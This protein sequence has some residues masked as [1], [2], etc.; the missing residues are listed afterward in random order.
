MDQ[1]NEDLASTLSGFQ[2]SANNT[3]QGLAAYIKFLFNKNFKQNSEFTKENLE[4]AINRTFHIAKGEL[5]GKLEKLR[6]SLTESYVGKTKTVPPKVKQLVDGTLSKLKKAMMDKVDNI[7]S[8]KSDIGYRKKY[9]SVWHAF[10]L[11]D[12][13]DEYNQKII[14]S[15]VIEQSDSSA[16]RSWMVECLSKMK[17]LLNYFENILPEEIES[18]VQYDMA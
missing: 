8:L 6:S 10:E 14:D 9:N 18:G 17:G 5:R 11:Q 16:L 2:P 12:V 3:S 1:L 13:L 7:I 15:S 4:S